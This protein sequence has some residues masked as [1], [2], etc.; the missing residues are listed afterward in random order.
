LPQ[1]QRK[2]VGIYV[3]AARY[4]TGNVE[5]QTDGGWDN[6][7]G[8]GLVL[9]DEQQEVH[10]TISARVNSRLFEQ[11]QSATARAARVQKKRTKTLEITG[12]I[13]FLSLYVAA[14][15]ICKCLCA[16]GA[17]YLEHL[18][19]M[20]REELPS[21]LG[22]AEPTEEWLKEVRRWESGISQAMTEAIG[23]T[24]LICYTDL[25]YDLIIYSDNAGSVWTVNKETYRGGSLMNILIGRAKDYRATCGLQV[26]CKY[27]PGVEN[28]PDIGSRP[29][30]HLPRHRVA[31]MWTD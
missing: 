27:V 30:E 17:D 5:E 11:V 16:K 14:R 6:V 1:N 2:A 22:D 28:I 20:S 7:R 18:E 24:W 29:N 12:M 25:D 8:I 31:Q 4:A 15:A 19:A 26:W 13:A 10:E 23:V 3:D 21:A 9:L